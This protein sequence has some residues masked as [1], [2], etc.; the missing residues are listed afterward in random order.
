MPAVSISPQPK[1]QF[2]DANGNPLAGGKLYTYAAG[3]TTPL[4]SYTDSTGNVANTNPVVLD[5]RGEA[6]VWLAGAQYKLALYTTSNVLVWT[7]DG[8]NGPDQATLATLAAS[9]G[10][11]LVGFLQAGTGAQLRTVQSKLR[12]AVSVRDFGAVGDSNGTTGNGTDDT[13]AIQAAV[14]FANAA[15]RSVYVP[16][17][18]YRITS[19]INF[20][21]SQTKAEFCGESNFNTI[22]FA[23]FTSVT[24]VAALSLNA[25]VGARTYVGFKNFQIK[26]RSVANVSGIYC[27][28][29]SE[30]TEIENVWVFQCYNGIVVANDYNVKITRCQTW[31]NVNNGIQIG[32]TLAGVLAPANNI[33]LAGCLS[34]YNGANGFYVK[35]ARTLGMLQCDGEANAYTN[36]YLDSVYGGSLVGTYM[37]YA[38]T[39]PA[40]PIAQLYMAD[41]TGIS[42][43]GLSVSAFDNSGNPVIFLDSGNNGVFLS[44]IAIETAGAPTN[45]IGLKVNDSYGITLAS[46]YLNALSAGL[47]ID[48]SAR[49]TI[50]QTNFSNCTTP[51]STTATGSKTVTWLDAVDAQLTASVSQIASNVRIDYSTISNQKNQINETKSFN[52]SISSAQLASGASVKI[53]DAVLASE[54]WRILGILAVGLTPFSGGNRNLSITNGTNTYTVIPSASLALAT[55]QAAW[56]TAD[57]PYSA[58]VSDMLQPTAVGGDLTALYSGGTT[59]HTA[60]D[61]NITVLA[62]RIA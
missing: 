5:S 32:F 24:P 9:G 6:S 25:S 31:Y 55:L 53:I 33:M 17:G 62:E 45:A 1:L 46:S 12:E 34:T 51:V 37:E 27:N 56:G 38:S 49:I 39:E 22:I 20:A 23:D 58:T 7:V 61:I 44:G 8:L 18:C 54:Q 36:I 40:N 3:T 19:P 15:G 48:N 16:T 52:V 47:Y 28:F 43:D 57:V 4:A 42:V 59:D 14:T 50:Q 2:F 30:F 11:A 21:G 29:G 26:G 41:C 10:S 60:G 35:A 13:A